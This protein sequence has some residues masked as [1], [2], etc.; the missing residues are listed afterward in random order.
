MASI[1]LNKHGIYAHRRWNTFSWWRDCITDFTEPR[2]LSVWLVY[3]TRWWWNLPFRQ[4]SFQDIAN[5]IKDVDNFFLDSDCQNCV[6]LTHECLRP[7]QFSSIIAINVVT[8]KS[9]ILQV[10][11]FKTV[12]YSL[13][14]TRTTKTLTIIIIII[15]SKTIKWLTF[16]V[17]Y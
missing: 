6:W 11:K 1:R 17:H 3:F 10:K 8:V 15:L 4:P 5:V 16:W 2:H 12:K 9:T 13:F 14:L 7:L